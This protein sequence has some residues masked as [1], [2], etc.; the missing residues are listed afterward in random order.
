MNSVKEFSNEMDILWNNITSNRAPGLSEFEKSVFLT[1]A[2]NELVRNYFIPNSK[3]NNLTMGFDES[4]FRQMN[5]STL[6]RSANAIKTNEDP[7]IDKRAMVYSLPANILCILNEQVVVK[8]T[9][10]NTSVE[11]PRQVIPISSTEYT[12]LMSKPFKEPMKNQAWR[13]IS[14]GANTPTRVELIIASDEKN[15]VESY[16]VRYVKTPVPIIL[17]DLSS[18]GDDIQ[19]E[20]VST[21]SM[22]ELDPSTH[23]AILQRAVELAKIAWEIDVNQTQMHMASGQRSE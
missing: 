9:I 21:E 1:K 3:G 7:I 15:Y 8:K 14:T 20:G 2:Q 11:V 6:M 22:C 10:N 19:I 13:L 16:T 5:F 23:D 17:E 4:G 12:R 18:Y